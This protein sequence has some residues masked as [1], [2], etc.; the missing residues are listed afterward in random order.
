MTNGFEEAQPIPEPPTV[1]IPRGKDFISQ[2]ALLTL[3]PLG[4]SLGP[5]LVPFDA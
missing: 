2:G 4:V 3:L 1:S 5:W